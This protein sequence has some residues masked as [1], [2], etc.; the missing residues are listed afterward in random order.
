MLNRSLAPPFQPITHVKLPAIEEI[1]LNN[2]Q[3]LSV[4]GFGTQEIIKIEFVFNAG[5][6]FTK[7][8]G[9]GALISKMLTGGTSK[10]TS[11][12]IASKFDQ[13]GAFTEIS[14]SVEHLHFIIYGLQKY[15]A[16][17][18][19]LFQEIITDCVFPEKELEIQK[20][21]ARQNLSLSL[22]KPAFL[23]N[24]RFRTLLFGDESPYGASHDIEDINSISRESLLDFYNSYI[25]NC[26]YQIFLSG[27][28]GKKEIDLVNTYFGKNQIKQTHTSDLIIA[29]RKPEK[30]K[31]ELPSGL[32]ST[33]RTGKILFGRTHPDFFKFLVMNT[34]FGGYFG[35]RLM[36]N[37]REEKGFTYGISSNI[38]PVVKSGYWLIGTDV[39]K[40]KTE[41]TISEIQKEIAI[42]Q[43]DL[44]KSE[45]LETVIN[46][47]S[48][49]FA[50]SIT[51]PIEIMDRHKAIL[52]NSLPK[53]YYDTY[54]EHIRDV[55]NQDIMEMAQQ[56]LNKETFTNVIVGGKY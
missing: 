39:I 11:K 36:R 53:D 35:S 45:E 54:I 20:N 50:G 30:D 7:N 55:K 14:Q 26:G 33:L 8:K 10:F 42:L 47:M 4:A 19:I 28:A 25:L 32:Q 22:E 6:R 51:N 9:L 56:Y 18:L 27:A 37:I 34:T 41:E 38:V 1:K 23:A 5:T 52:L 12:E 17:Y 29:E 3:N 31:I 21:I 13:H 16:N 43:Q 49:S 40:E 48:G 44:I 15:L 46:Y 2:L 24:R